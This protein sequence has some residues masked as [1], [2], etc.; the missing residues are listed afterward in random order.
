MNRMYGYS[1]KVDT[2]TLRKVSAS[3]KSTKDHS[4]IDLV[5]TPRLR[6]ITIC[7]GVFWFA[8]AFTY[9]GISFKITGFGLNMYLTHFLYAV[10]E[11]PAKL[12][13]YFALDRIGR[14]NGQACADSS[15]FFTSSISFIC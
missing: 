4:Y 3:E 1:T 8:V 14:R 11:I 13:T 5:R 2:E 7:A 6:K 15:D 10:I 12:G 9:Y